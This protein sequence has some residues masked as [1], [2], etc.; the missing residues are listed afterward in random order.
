MP[1]DDILIA[2]IRAVSGRVEQFASDL[3][4]MVRL[5]DLFISGGAGPFRHRCAIPGGTGRSLGLSPG[6]C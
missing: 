5:M 1:A 4:K 6:D 2:E 3:L